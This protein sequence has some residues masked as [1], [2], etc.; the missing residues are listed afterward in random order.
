MFFSFCSFWLL[1]G[2]AIPCWLC[3]C[4]PCV[5]LFDSWNLYT[6]PTYCGLIR[7]AQTHTHTHT[8]A[9][10]GDAISIFLWGY[11]HELTSFIWLVLLCIGQPARQS[12]SMDSLMN[13]LCCS[14][15]PS[16]TQTPSPI[17]TNE[18]FTLNCRIHLMCA[19]SVNTCQLIGFYTVQNVW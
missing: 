11:L 4:S 14:F 17:Q 9:R 1:L 2:C 6:K 5:A 3:V 15:L 7:V 10:A 13:A 12:T 16:F 18:F 8:H 19:E